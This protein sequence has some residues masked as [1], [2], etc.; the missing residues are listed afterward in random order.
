MNERSRMSFLGDGLAWL[1][2]A[3]IT[4][5]GAGGGGSHI[6][7]Q[8]AHLQVGRLPVVDHDRLEDTNVNRVVGVGYG[9]VGYLKAN[10]LARRFGDL[11][12]RIIAVPERAESPV[13]RRWIEQSDVVFG[14]V[15]GTRARDNIENIC[16]AALIPYIDIGM[17]IL[18]G[19]DEVT[20]EGIGGQ[21]VTSLPGG[22]CL[23]CAEVVTEDSLLADREEYV[24]GWP[25][26]QVVSING[27]LGSQAVSGMLN[28]MTGYAP[29]FPPTA[30]IRYDGLRHTMT[31]DRFIEGPCPHYPLQDAGWRTILPDRV[32]AA[33]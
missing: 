24:A 12:T 28:V 17:K 4:V 2:G 29:D 10:L 9:A 25:E 33:C 13:A 20:V 15:D 27:L 32:V 18:M 21:V 31:P 5:V 26:Q 16:R 23:R 1:R 3:T 19:E 11:K 8:I 14:A 7:Q 22:P 6:V 30:V